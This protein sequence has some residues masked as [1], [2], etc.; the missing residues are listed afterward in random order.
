LAGTAGTHQLVTEAE[1]QLSESFA[2]EV[3]IF[4]PD[5]SGTLRATLGGPSSFAANDKEIA[6]AQWV[7]SH[8]QV[9][10]AGTDTLTNASALYLPLSS[11]H[12]T[13][14][15]LALRPIEL[16]RFSSPDQRQLLETLAS[17]IAMAIERD[18]LAEQAQKVLVQAEAERLRSSL[19]SSVSHDLRTP[20]AVIAGASS[21]LLEAG[22]SLD[23][24]G[25]RELLQTIVE[26]SNRLAV[27]VDNLLHI[28]RIE[29]SGVAVNKQ[30]CPVE[31]VV[32]SALERTK[33][34]LAGRSV[35]THL[36]ADLP[37]VKLD[38]VLIEQV[39]INLLEN[40][41]KYTPAGSPLDL[42]ARVEGTEAV[43]E[44]A[45]RGPGLGEEERQRVFDKC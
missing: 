13:V 27:L 4:L 24:T 25:R 3:A 11:S 18:R 7:F 41:A 43:L 20:L 39:L 30:W 26:E 12:D 23:E 16:A 9:A 22:G 35:Q 5:A 17:Q 42:L 38:G 33:K 15:V 36:P 2:S 14:G 31:E 40:A 19:L 1:M 44:V 45:D 28:T 21:S 6:V 34:Q 10:G 29:A 37:L 8:G 32:G